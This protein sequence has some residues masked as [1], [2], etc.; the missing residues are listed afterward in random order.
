MIGATL[1]CLAFAGIAFAQ[2]LVDEEDTVEAV[3]KDAR[4]TQLRQ[5]IHLA[6][7]LSEEQ[8]LQLKDLRFG[9]QAELE[10]IR[11]RVAEGDLTSFEGREE[12]RSARRAHRISTD[13]IMTVEQRALLERGRRHIRDLELD[14][15]AA[16]DTGARHFAHLVEA[17][18]LTDEQ[19]ESWHDLLREQRERYQETKDE[20]LE[21][22]E[23]WEEGEIVSRFRDEHKARF[24]MLLSDEQLTKLEEIR[25]DWEQRRRESFEIDGDDFGAE[26]FDRSTAIDDDS[27]GAVKSDSL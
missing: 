1:V 12:Y 3:S 7:N 5:R 17:L 10:A 21:G 9:L 25:A 15:E 20:M 4:M 27:W 18:E 26:E 13:A 16:G 22:E 6:L 23:D 2:G 14:R 11:E 24:R 19:K 8:E